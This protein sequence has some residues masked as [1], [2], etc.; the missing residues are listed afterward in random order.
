MGLLDRLKK[1]RDE[2]AQGAH[3]RT[4]HRLMVIGLDCAPPELVFDEYAGD[5]PN[6]TKPT[7]VINAFKGWYTWG[8]LTY[9]FKVRD[10]LKYSNGT[11]PLS[12]SCVNGLRQ[13]R[14][15]KQMLI[16]T[17]RMPW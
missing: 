13:S 14:P 16:S 4:G 8:G 3:A 15:G 9:K 11:P 1:R 2:E 10:G 7:S 6:L 17:F 12:R 5:I